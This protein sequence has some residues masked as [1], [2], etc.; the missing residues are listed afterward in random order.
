[1]RKSPQNLAQWTQ[2][3]VGAALVLLLLVIPLALIFTQVIAGGWTLFTQNMRED[4]M[5]HAIGLTLFIA[6]LTVP[7]NT[8]FG[9]LL[10]WCMT[11]YQFRGKRLLSLFVDIPY[12]VSPVV[13]GLCYL[14]VYGVETAVGRWFVGHNIQ[15]MFAWPGILLVTIFVTVPYVAR[16]LIPVMQAQGSD[17]EEAAL[18][19]GANGWQIFWQVSLPNIR[20]GLIYGVVLTNARAIGEFGAVS[21]VSGTIMNQTL[22]LSLLVEQLNNDY[23][24]AAAFTAAALLA[25]MAILTVALKSILEWRLRNSEAGARR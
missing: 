20:W 5:L 1:M 19:L 12:A 21:V 16:I 6:V 8:M 25:C 22:T 24:T 18:S 13:A 17:H 23:K 11:H 10:A 4:F 3:I 14:V 15:L 9:V 7:L 2:V